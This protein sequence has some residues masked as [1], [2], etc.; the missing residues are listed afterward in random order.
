MSIGPHHERRRDI[1]AEC[2]GGPQVD[3]EAVRSRLLDRQLGR[4]RPVEDF[5]HLQGGMSA[6]IEKTRTMR[7]H[8]RHSRYS[9]A[10]TDVYRTDARR[11]ADA[12]ERLA[13]CDPAGAACRPATACVLNAPC[14]GNRRGCIAKTGAKHLWNATV[15][16]IREGISRGAQLAISIRAITCNGIVPAPQSTASKR[17]ALSHGLDPFRA[18]E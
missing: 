9:A 13:A 8:R 12:A 7:H 2:S 5:V 1:E 17:A 10:A 11:S 16:C 15:G 18:F 4:F 14:G 6:R 3:N